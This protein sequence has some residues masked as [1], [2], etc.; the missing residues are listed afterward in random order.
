MEEI[1]VLRDLLLIFAIGLGVAFLLKKIGVPS[2]AGFIV[3]GILI[4][5]NAVGIISDVHEVELLAEIGVVLVLFGIGLEL[6]LDKLKRMW[7]PVLIGGALQ[8][9]LSIAA[10][11]GVATAFSVPLGKSI[12]LGCM[13]A[14]SSTAIVLRGLEYRGEIDAP[15]GRFALGILVFQDLCVV[16]MMLAIPLLAGSAGGGWAPALSL[17][18]AVLVVGGVVVASRIAVPRFLHIIAHTGQRDLFVLAVLL[19]CIG[20]AWVVSLFGISLALGAFLAGMVVAGS[21][22][23]HQAMADLIPFREVLASMFFISVGMLLDP[24]ALIREPLPIFGLFAAIMFGKAL[25]ILFV[26]L[27]MRIPLRVTLIT[28][29]ILSQMGEFLFVLARAAE[30]TGLLDGTLTSQLMAAAILSMLVTPLLMYMSP[31]FAAGV[32][33]FGMLQRYMGVDNGDEQQH[34][35]HLRDHVI[36]AGYGIAGQELASALRLQDIPYAIVEL[37]AETVR[38]LRQKKEP[39][40]FGD[41]ISEEMLHRLG[42]HRARELVIAISDPNAALRALG[43]ARRLAPDLPILIRSRYVGEVPELLDMGAT[44]VVPS[45]YESAVEIVSQVLS[46]NGIPRDHIDA[47]VENMH[48]RCRVKKLS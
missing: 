1:T 22:Y 36:I 9:G 19:V 11:V 30:G 45:E 40:F 42:I 21:D 4:G 28:G 44:N 18:K 8:V 12:F 31:K 37:N 2:L 27:I 38:K 16:P 24:G 39:A 6:S 3:A 29:M 35:Q 46:R 23:R 48:L 32:T 14:I 10:T 15:H 43:A 33:K 26:G 25:I 20:T 41:V 47:Y 7:K 5:P 17:G 13:V 34:A